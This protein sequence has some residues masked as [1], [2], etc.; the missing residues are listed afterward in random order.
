MKTESVQTYNSIFPVIL[1]FFSLLISSDGFG[2]I[3]SKIDSLKQVID[4]AK[5]DTTLVNAYMEWDNI[6]YLSDPNLDL[7]INKKIE[8]ICSRNL[9]DP[10][11]EI[12]EKLYQSSLSFVLRIIGNTY[13]SKENYAL[14][15]QYY[16]R[17]FNVYLQM[18][19]GDGAAKCLNNLGVVYQD[20]GNLVKAIGY[21]NRS[22]KLFEKTKNDD[23]IATN[24]VNIGSIYFDQEDYKRA[25]EYYVNSLVIFKKLKTKVELQ[26]A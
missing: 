9:Q 23:G 13:L 22:R 18:G 20:K 1:I 3:E 7:E 25:N 19:N 2:Q 16:T 5:H 26:I 10:L 12:E 14:A 17:S 4:T 24:L 8:V 11:D 6:I 21:F 15:T